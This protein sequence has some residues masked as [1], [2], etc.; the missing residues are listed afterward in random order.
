MFSFSS[1]V[2]T[3][4]LE[5]ERE[6]IP[7]WIKPLNIYFLC[8]FFFYS[9]RNM[10]LVSRCHVLWRRCVAS[11]RRGCGNYAVRKPLP[12]CRSLSTVHKRHKVRSYLWR[13]EPVKTNMA[14]TCQTRHMSKSIAANV[15]LECIGTRALSAAYSTLLELYHSY[16]YIKQRVC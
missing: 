9:C 6:V 11:T 1:F 10:L 14:H 8:L 5:R 7:A 3:G 12:V 15:S 16:Q 13:S 4:V 2:S